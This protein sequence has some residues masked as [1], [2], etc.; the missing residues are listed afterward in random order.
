MGV[1]LRSSLSLLLFNA[2]SYIEYIYLPQINQ[3]LTISLCTHSAGTKESISMQI[4]MSKKKRKCSERDGLRTRFVVMKLIRVLAVFQKLRMM[5]KSIS[6]IWLFYRSVP[7]R[8]DSPGQYKILFNHYPF[9]IRLWW[10]RRCLTR[11]RPSSGKKMD[12]K[13]RRRA[14]RI[15]LLICK[16]PSHP[17]AAWRPFPSLTSK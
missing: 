2:S 10:K 15:F 3:S 4:W 8:P 13:N 12:R 1:V 9:L 6:A 5:S 16:S 14:F 17:K 11:L 7:G